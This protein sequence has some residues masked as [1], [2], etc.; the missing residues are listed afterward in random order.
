MAVFLKGLFSA[1][2]MRLD[3]Y[4]AECSRLTYAFCLHSYVAFWGVC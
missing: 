4:E 2:F 3:T 1:S